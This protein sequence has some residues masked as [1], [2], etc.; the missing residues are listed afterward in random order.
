MQLTEQIDELDNF[1]CI[2]LHIRPIIFICRQN[3]FF[4]VFVGFNFL[5]KIA[6]RKIRIN[7]AGDKGFHILLQHFTSVIRPHVI[8][9]RKNS[10]NG[11]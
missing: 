11:S 6:A 3:F 8:Y 10:L 9:D 4:K 1:Y 7:F 2:N 5:V